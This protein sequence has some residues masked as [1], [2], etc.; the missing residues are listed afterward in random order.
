MASMHRIAVI[1]SSPAVINT[2]KNILE[3]ANM[4]PTKTT[5]QVNII[6]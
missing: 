4:K 2:I 3:L 6:N 5:A 1:P